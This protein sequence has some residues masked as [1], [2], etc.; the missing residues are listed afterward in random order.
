MSRQKSSRN[1]IVDKVAKMTGYTKADV[2]KVVPAVFA[3]LKELLSES[4]EVS[5]HDFGTFFVRNIKSRK[6]RNIW[7][8]ETLTIKESKYISFKSSKSLKKLLNPESLA[9]YDRKE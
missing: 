1:L 4:E 9:V 5:I 7:T 2:M 8:G 6:G 3:A